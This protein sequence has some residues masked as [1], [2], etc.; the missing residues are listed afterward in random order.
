MLINVDIFSAQWRSF[1]LKKRGMEKGQIASPMFC[2]KP[3]G[4]FSAFFAAAP[5]GVEPRLL[6]NPSLDTSRTF[7]RK[8]EP[9]S[10]PC[11]AW[12]LLHWGRSRD[13]LPFRQLLILSWLKYRVKLVSVSI[14]LFVF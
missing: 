13:V 7:L 9:Q 6:Y 2:L 1:L 11:G 14:H 4:L 10:P 12:T 8:R 3:M 5:R